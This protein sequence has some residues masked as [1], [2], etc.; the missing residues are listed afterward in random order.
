[1]SE[2]PQNKCDDD[3]I[4]NAS[5]SQVC[6]ESRVQEN[7]ELE[8]TQ[9]LLSHSFASHSAGVQENLQRL[10]DET[11]EYTNLIY[12]TKHIQNKSESTV[13]NGGLRTQDN[14]EDEFVDDE[15]EAIKWDKIM[16]QPGCIKG[17]AKMRDYQLEG[18]NW[19]YQLWKCGVNGILADEMGLGKTLQTISLLGFLHEQSLDYGP[20]IVICPKSTITNWEREFTAWC[21]VLKVVSLWGDKDD[22]SAIIQDQLL[23]NP[24]DVCVTTPEILSREKTSLVS[25]KWNYLIVD[26]AHRIK[27]DVSVFSKVVRKI[28]CRNRLLLTGT[29]LQ[30]SVKELWALLN[31]IMPSSFQSAEQFMTLFDVS[32][33]QEN[34]RDEVLKVLHRILKPFMLRR[35]KADVEHRIPPK[36]ELYI[37]IGMPIQ[38]KELYSRILKG[39]KYA[40]TQRGRRDALLNVL[41][42]L[43]KCCNHPYLFVGQEP[44][45]FQ[46]GPHLYQSAGKMVLLDKLLARLKE[47]SSRV[48]LF[49]QMTRMLTI[50]DDYLR[51]KGYTYCRIDGSTPSQQRQ[52]QI[53]EFN[54]SESKYFIFLLSTRAG[55]LGINLATANVV[56]LYDSDFNPQ[57]DLQAIDR[58][59]RIGQKNPVTVYRFV[60]QETVEEQIVVRAAKRLYLDSLVI[61]K[62]KFGAARVGA[63]DK[64]ELQ[65]IVQFGAQQILETRNVSDISDADIDAIIAAAEERTEKIR[66]ELCG[67][68][69]K[70]G[71]LD[72]KLDEGILVHADQKSY[73]KFKSLLEEEEMKEGDT[74]ER[75]LARAEKAEAMAPPPYIPKRWEVENL[76]GGRAEGFH[77]LNTKRLSEIEKLEDASEIK[78]GKLEERD[79]IKD[80]SIRSKGTDKKRKEGSHEVVT[81]KNRDCSKTDFHHGPEVT[82]RN[83]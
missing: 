33:M 29:P 56:I 7:R 36:K 35:L 69:T 68:E 54:K 6:E 64:D 61:R 67:L 59:H 21:P 23:S 50:L 31:F 32:T 60:T 16:V 12:G 74:L 40:F 75:R 45:P 10:L 17:E 13:K 19:L 79:K 25:L 82:T 14:N 44:Q 71:K 65:S 39:E 47:S 76:L 1:M 18:L 51:W 70:F 80:K 5:D 52:E 43:R 28:K 73:K 9:H 34:H 62:G 49:S 38:Q 26:E 72:L 63:P 30:N 57:V 78:I 11:A 42:Q 41:M 8:D 2:A 81:N 37:F 15:D 20:H 58:A 53:D 77:F 22:R 83:F 48:L 4:N 27:N 24:F 46:D 55:G 3:Q 66:L